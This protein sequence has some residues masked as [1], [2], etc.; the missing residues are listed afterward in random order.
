MAGLLSFLLFLPFVA[1]VVVA[2]LGE[3]QRWARFVTYGSL[4]ATNVALLGIVAVALLIGLLQAVSPQTAAQDTLVGKRW[5]VSAIC[6]L[7]SAVASLL[8]VPA[9]RRFLARWLPIDPGSMVHMT[10][11]AFAVYWIGLSATELL[12]IGDLQALT[13][14]DMSLSILDVLLTGLP[15]LLFAFVGVGL[16][17]RRSGRDVLDRLGL[18]RPTGKQLLAAAGCTVLL[19]VFDFGVNWAWQA[20][21]P[22]GFDQLQQVTG[23]LYGGLMSVAGALVLGLSAGISEESLFR[24]AVQPRLGLLLSTILFALGHLQYGLTVATLEIFVIGLVL[25]LMRRRTNTTTTILIHAGYN[26]IGVL[27][28]LLK[29]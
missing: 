8:L 19:L 15:L 7:A 27:L 4:I 17:T 26:T 18:C 23:K 6:L 5:A 16:F 29:P 13:Q 28:G 1:L 20:L 21:D 2:N 3:R 14:A 12:L 22:S 25:G 10:A 24:G 11:L 9:V